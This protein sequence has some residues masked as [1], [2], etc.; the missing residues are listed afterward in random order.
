MKDATALINDMQNYDKDNIPDSIINKI[1]PFMEDENFEPKQIQKASKACTAICMWVR[2][3]HMYHNVVLMVEPKKKQLAEAQASLEVTMAA[4]A[5]AQATLKE[6]LDKIA[7]LEADLKAANDKKQA[8]ADQ[9][10]Q[11]TGRLGRAEQL[12]GGLGGEK[13]RWTETC[14]RLEHEYGDLVGDAVVSAA[15][16][17]YAGPFTPDFRRLL[18][19]A[20]QAKLVSLGIPHTPGCDVRQTLSD[21]VV[22]RG[23]KLNQL[24]QDSHSLENG[25]IMSKARRYPLF[26]DPQGQANKFLKNM[27]RDSNF[28]ANGLDIIKLSDKNFLRT[29]ENGV[30]FGK[31]VLLE[32]V[33]EAL[34]ASL[35][36]LLLQQK[37]KQGGQE[38]IKIGDSTV[39]WN[40][41]FGFFITTKLPNPHYPPE[42]CVKVSLLNFAITFSGLEDQLLG[43]CVIEERPDMEEKKTSLVIANARMKNELKAIEDTIL[44]LLAN[45]TGNILD[46]VELIETLG[47]SKVT[48]DMI[49][50]KV[51]EAEKTE[52]EI[53]ANRELYR[54]VAYYVAILYFCVSDLGTVDPMYQFSLQWFTNLFTKVN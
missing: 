45:S 33:G 49:N 44:K 28:C 20:W 22:I 19:D 24:P 48:A 3:M 10:E 17:A 51:A 38:M 18:V 50:G 30:R 53:D 4:L 37:F 14:A 6:V 31:W 26:I 21:E 15:M 46:D 39:P 1:N 35:E 43:V 13:V 16:I 12:M 41:A 27:G 36:T 42:V 47:T 11:A 29:L 9:M 5:R 52:V 2:A 23:W 25:I 54:P 32:N 40:D 7:S 8:L 34:D